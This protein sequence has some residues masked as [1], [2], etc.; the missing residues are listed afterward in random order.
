MPWVGGGVVRDPASLWLPGEPAR[1][2]L[3]F[4]TS[5]GDLAGLDLGGVDGPSAG[6]VS[7]A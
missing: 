2:N 5:N 4:S 6:G 7:S 1:R 3:L